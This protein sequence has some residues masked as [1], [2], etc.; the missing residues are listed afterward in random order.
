[1]YRAELEIPDPAD[2]T[3]LAKVTSLVMS[4]EEFDELVKLIGEGDPVVNLAVGQ[5][6]RPEDVQAL[7]DAQQVP[8]VARGTKTEYLFKHYAIEGRYFCATVRGLS[9]RMGFR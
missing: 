9:K 7:A 4:Q 5:R 1:M 2:R 8:M 6:M 3:K